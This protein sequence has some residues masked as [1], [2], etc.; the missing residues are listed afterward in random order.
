MAG[1]KQDGI[2]IKG[3]LPWLQLKQVPGIGNLLFKRLLDAFGTPEKVLSAPREALARV[4]GISLSLAGRIRRPGDPTA[5]RREIE[6]A[7]ARGFRILPLTDPQYPPLL[8]E[9]P[10]PPPLLYVHGCLDSLPWPLAMVGARKASRYGLDITRRLA[11]ELAAAGALIVSGMARGIDTA[12]HRA[13]LDAGGKTVAVLGSGLDQIYPPEN[14]QLFRQIT[15][16][17]A[18]ISEFP[19]DTR[20]EPRNFPVR[21]RI[22]SG[23]SL[24]TV[25][26]EA[27]RRSGSLIT[28]RLAA[29]QNREVFAVP[30][31]V[32]SGLSHG[33]HHLIHQGAKLVTAAA[34]IW[35][36][37]THLRPSPQAKAQPRGSGAE[38][39]AIDKTLTKAERQ[40]WALL[41]PYPIHIDELAQES[42]L[43]PGQLAEALLQLELKGLIIQGAGKMFTK[44]DSN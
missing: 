22:I 7:R 37:F 42:S 20:P 29:E 44:G 31:S 6:N 1:E 4:Q 18:V 34:D 3:L 15:R 24:G 27:A 2:N 26:V 35:E 33:T 25:V 16:Q 41:S 12:A 10:D 8:R 40:V 17:G 13:A 39:G 9:I 21:N 36:E 43:A 19:L 28:A 14:R 32:R 23:M 30:G 11:A 38:G 5:S